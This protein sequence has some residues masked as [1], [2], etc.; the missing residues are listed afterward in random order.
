MALKG[1]IWDF[2]GTMSQTGMRQY[3]WFQQWAKDNGK[4]L[5][6]EGNPLDTFSK[7]MGFYNTVIQA[8]G[9]QGVYDALG[10]PCTMNDKSHPVWVGYER[11]KRENPVQLYPGIADAV[12]LFQR[13]GLK[14]G[15]NTTNKIASIE[16]E[17]VQAGIL[18]V[19]D[20]VI[21]EE[22]LADYHGAGNQEAIKKPSKISLYLALEELGIAG[23]EAVHVGDTVNDLAASKRVM[24]LNPRRFVDIYVVGMTYGFEG[25]EVLNK[26]VETPNGT[27]HFDALADNA[28]G[29]VEIVA[30]LL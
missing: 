6:H 7:F 29:L 2:D 27:L 14:Q 13:L 20:S 19:F 28:E 15:I 11:F 5:V 16:K 18:A 30:R 4:T 8:N 3:L 26:G 10:L 23:D 9:P 22:T 1:V 12:R 25:R 21:T 17:L 24:R